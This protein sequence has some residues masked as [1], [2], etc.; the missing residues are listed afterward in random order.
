MPPTLK[1]LKILFVVA[2]TGF[3][4]QELATSR[5]ILEEAGAV[6]VLATTAGNE[7]VSSD[8][9]AVET[10]P[11][12]EPRTQEMAG[13][14]VIGGT[15]ASEHLWENG[16]VQ[17]A[18]RMIERDG[19]PVGALSQGVVVLARAGMLQG[20]AATTWVSADTLKA[21]KD[22]GARYEKKPLVIA[23]SILTADG[24]ASAER[25]G[26]LLRDM[27]DASRQKSGAIPRPVR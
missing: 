5:R 22:G 21:L 7:A 18:V 17:K 4:E 3:H 26:V 25:F 16:L 2:P 14:V 1:G 13:A 12:T 10:V 8:G 24:P 15:G 23:G 9:T 19:K 11:I 20:K 6:A 27:I